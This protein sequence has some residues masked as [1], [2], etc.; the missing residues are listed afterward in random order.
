[1]KPSFLLF[2]PISTLGRVLGTFLGVILIGGL[3]S[4]CGKQ[5]SADGEPERASAKKPVIVTTTTMVTDLVRLV[6][7]DVF[8][9]KPLM[10]PGV[11]PHLYKPTQEDVG[12]L[13]KANLIIYSGL[14]LEGK[15]IDIFRHLAGQEKMTL[16]LGD[17]LPVDRILKL[18]GSQ[19]DPHIWGDAK[20]WSQT[21][22]P[23]VKFLSKAY[24]TQTEEFQRRGRDVVTNLIALHETLKNMAETLPRRNRLLVTSHDAFHYFGQAY[25]FEVLG[26]QGISTDSEAGLNDVARVIDI[27]KQKQVR[28]IFVE[29][30]VPPATIQR[31]SKDSGAL[32]GGE[33]LS[34]ALG[35][36]GEMV[37]LEDGQKVDRGTVIGM[38]LSNMNTVVKALKP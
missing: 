11:D 30:S 32:I 17:A 3:M 13:K 31:I 38:L 34:D 14:H 33:L 19:S 21:V 2:S 12:K 18:E 37:T 8:E 4:G 23:L 7:G 27:I 1:M 26:V 35:L 28:A 16:G 5:T 15:M 10:G 6:A 25:G 20:L 24:P 22:P 29:S 9:I 36:P